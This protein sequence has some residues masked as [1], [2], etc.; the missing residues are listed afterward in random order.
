EREKPS[1][2]HFKP[3]H[4]IDYDERVARLELQLEKYQTLTEIEELTKRAKYVSCPTSPHSPCA[5]T[6]TEPP[7]PTLS[8]SSQYDIASSVSLLSRSRY[9]Q[10]ESIRSWSKSVQTDD[11][12]SPLARASAWVQ[13]EDTGPD[14]IRGLPRTRS[15]MSEILPSLVTDRKTYFYRPSGSVSSFSLCSST[16]LPEE[17]EAKTDVSNEPPNAMLCERCSN[18]KV[19][20]ASTQTDFL[21]ELQPGTVPISDTSSSSSPSNAVSISQHPTDSCAGIPPPPPMP[22]SSSIPPP[23]PMPGTSSIPPPPPPPPP[24]MPGSSIPPPPPPPPPMPGCGP[25]P[26]PPPPGCGAPP[27]PPPGFG[28]PTLPQPYIVRKPAIIPKQPMRPLYWTRIQINAPA[29]A[30]K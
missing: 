19:S 15:D 26:P 30:E 16:L 29:S 6:Q 27:P 12:C 23:P 25:P 3:V 7:R 24:P 4:R 8:S 20:L 11:G 17:H 9:C 5:S 21:S 10:T 2:F 28:A 1:V 18:L 14:V 22:G 13:T